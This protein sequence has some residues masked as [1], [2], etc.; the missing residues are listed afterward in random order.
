[1]IENTFSLVADDMICLRSCLAP[2]S[3]SDMPYLGIK[4]DGANPIRLNFLA[5]FR[6]SKLAIL[7][8]WR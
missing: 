7:S 6:S 2:P 8:H 4:T 5:N 3:K 1:M